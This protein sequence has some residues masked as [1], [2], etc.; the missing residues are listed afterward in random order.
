MEEAN[1]KHDIRISDLLKLGLGLKARFFPN[2]RGDNI[3][4]QALSLLLQAGINVPWTPA[5]RR[6]TG[7]VQEIAL[8]AAL[9]AVIRRCCSGEQESALCTFPVSQA[10]FGADI[11]LELPISGVAA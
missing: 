6:I 10:T 11:P 8:F 4:S 5:F 2:P 7:H 1:P 9:R 3:L